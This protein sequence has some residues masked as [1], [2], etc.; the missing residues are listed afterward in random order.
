MSSL[1][2]AEP[3]KSLTLLTSESIKSADDFSEFV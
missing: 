2:C 3:A 1:C